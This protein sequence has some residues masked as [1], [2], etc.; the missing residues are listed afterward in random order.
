MSAGFIGTLEAWGRLRSA[1]SK[2]LSVDGLKYFKTSEYKMLDG[3]FSKFKTAAYPPPSGRNAAKKIRAD[4]QALVERE[5]DIHGVGV[6]IPVTDYN[7]VCARPE[8]QGVMFGDPYHRALESVMWET[9]QAVAKRP[10]RNMV[11]FV[12]DDGSDFADLHALYKRFLKINK[13]TAK[14]IAGFQPLDDKLHPP[15]QAADM[16]ANYTLSISQDWLASG[17]EKQ[18][19]LEMK[20]SIKLLGVWEKHYILSLLKRSLIARGKPIP[21]DL[22]GDEYG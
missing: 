7:E 1:W 19:A 14:Y 17:R 6:A 16:M 18:K 2:R 9:A 11:V 8:A 13:K 20:R 5:H 12:H 22:K 21:I 10:G 15:L 4:L 3:E